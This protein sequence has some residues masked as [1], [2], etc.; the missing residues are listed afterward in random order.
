MASQTLYIFWRGDQSESFNWFI[1]AEGEISQS[2]DSSLEDMVSTH[3]GVKTILVVPTE[4]LL[5]TTVKIPT[6]QRQKLQQAVPF[7]LE[8][9]LV[10]DIED[11][12]FAIGDLDGEGQRSV[13]V[14]ARTRMTQWLQP[15]DNVGL[16]IQQLIPDLF[17]V[18]YDEHSWTLLLEEERALLRTALDGGVALPVEDVANLING[19]LSVIDTQDG[20]NPAAL[21]LYDCREGGEAL[22]F[23][24]ISIPLETHPC[25]SD[26]YQVYAAGIKN[27]PKLDLLQG[28]FNRK[29]QIWRSLRPWRGVAALAVFLVVLNLMGWGIEYRRLLDRDRQLQQALE[30]TYR[31]TFPKARRVINPRLQMEQKLSKL[32][33]GSSR[34]DFAPLMVKAMPVLLDIDGVEVDV[35]R[36]KPDSLEVDLRLKELQAIDQ[37][38]E[39]MS[40]NAFNVTVQNA[41]ATGG[42][43]KGRIVI[44]RSDS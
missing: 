42:Q 21:N 11:L 24:E 30:D 31:S 12:H 8:E 20:E 10:D 39:V 26:R 1:L 14:V 6:R 41:S 25:D 32:K 3:N 34:G 13:A 28:D 5:L 37:I 36:Y 19:Q 9:Q 4:D 29:Q 38:K 40:E 16:R 18:P 33:Q 23:D 35:L 27:G 15:F 17:T 43:A 2:G 44:S 22:S 7:V